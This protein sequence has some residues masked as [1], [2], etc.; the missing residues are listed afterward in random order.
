MD[1]ADTG[2]TVCQTSTKT[3]LYYQQRHLNYQQGRNKNGDCRRAKATD[4]F[5]IPLLSVVRSRQMKSSMNFIDKRLDKF[6][7]CK[8]F[9][10]ADV[11]LGK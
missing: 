10:R 8:T 7:S 2:H 11:A 5:L 6:M 1:E 3:C 4:D 9:K